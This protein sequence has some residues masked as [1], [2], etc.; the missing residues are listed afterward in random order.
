MFLEDGVAFFQALQMSFLR[1]ATYQVFCDVLIYINNFPS[2]FSCPDNPVNIGTQGVLQIIWF[3]DSPF[4]INSLMT[5]VHAIAKRFPVKLFRVFMTAVTDNV[6]LF[7][8]QFRF[9]I[10]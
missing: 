5:D 6:T 2:L 10:I 8:D 7:I 4:Y 3:G 1:Q 9:A